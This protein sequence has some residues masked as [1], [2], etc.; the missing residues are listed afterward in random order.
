M[1]LLTDYLLKHWRYLI[2]PILGMFITLG[3]DAFVP[4]LQQTFIDDILLG[5]QTQYLLSF[6]GIFLGLIFIRCIFGYIKE[7]AFDKF[8]LDV[9]KDLRKAI[10]YKV[11]TFDFSFFDKIGRAHV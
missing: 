8:S 4:I 7:Y 1:R 9:A 2:L 3:I 10:F 6:G 11:Q 5:N